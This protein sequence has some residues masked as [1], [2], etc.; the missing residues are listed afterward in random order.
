MLYHIQT[1]SQEEQL[2]KPEMFRW[3]RHLGRD[4]VDSSLQISKISQL[5]ASSPHSLLPA[6]LELSVPQS[7]LPY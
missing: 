3:K 2:H 4:K 6:H 1:M 7:G 5:H